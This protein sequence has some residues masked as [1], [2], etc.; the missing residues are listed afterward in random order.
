MKIAKEQLVGLIRKTI[1]EQLSEQRRLRSS[2]PLSNV[3]ANDNDF[4]YEPVDD[5]TFGPETTPVN[6]GKSLAKYGPGR[7]TRQAT[8]IQEDI[9]DEQ[10]DPA[11]P[12][13][14]NLVM[15]IGQLLTQAVDHG[16]IDSSFRRSLTKAIRG[17][18]QER[19]GFKNY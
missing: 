3:I 12:E 11:V 15:K 14:R 9:D 1:R 16:V 2:T 7:L 8:S 19:Y 10:P 13:R 18:F 6:T 4:E 17:A 5:P